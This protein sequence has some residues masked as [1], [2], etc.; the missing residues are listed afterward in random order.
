MADR[1]E[2]TGWVGWAIFASVLM[3]L[4]GGFNIIYGLVALFDD[5]K[6]VATKSALV[7]FDFTTWGWVLLIIGIVQVFA[8]MA[9]FSGRLWGRIVGMVMAGLNA[10]GQIAFLQ[11][12]PV[13]SALI[14]L[15]DVLVIYA[16]TVHG[17]EMATIE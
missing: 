6:L 4:V 13:W 3:V 8:A 9:V 11:A 14:I 1:R 16:L 7:V 10:W 12:Q 2:P 5:Q 15:V 17:R